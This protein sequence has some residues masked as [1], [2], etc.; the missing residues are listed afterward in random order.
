MVL[1]GAG[2]PG[3]LGRRAGHLSRPQRRGVG[4]VKTD[5]LAGQ[6]VVIDRLGEQ[7][8][9]EGIAVLVGRDQDVRLDG[10]TQG[11]VEVGR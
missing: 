9:P 2:V 11:K 8:V 3:E 5:P 4:R 1:R 10:L 6:Q 7:C